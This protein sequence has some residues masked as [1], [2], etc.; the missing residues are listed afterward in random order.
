VPQKGSEEVDLPD[1]VVPKEDLASV[2]I[3]RKHDPWIRLKRG[4]H[5]QF[6]LY[7]YR[8]PSDFDVDKRRPQVAREFYFTINIQVLISPPTATSLF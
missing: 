1:R 2:F 7:F 4:C 3:L 5:L 8:L 6:R